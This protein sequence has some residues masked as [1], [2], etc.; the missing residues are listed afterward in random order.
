[1]ENGAKAIL[2]AGGILIGVIVITIGVLLFS[3][4][5]DNTQLFDKRIQE[6][7]INKFNVNFT[8][9]EGRKDITIQEIVS[10]INFA[11]QYEKEN[12]IHIQIDV[13]NIP[14][15]VINSDNNEIKLIQDNSEKTY[16]CI[17]N[18]NQ[19]IKYDDKGKIYYIKF[20]KNI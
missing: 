18:S 12:E 15:D 5:R 20:T 3:S 8:K 9:F 7:E 14:P 2:I 13:S 4:Y 17:N 1:M 16:S 10:L 6:N 19:D 11:E